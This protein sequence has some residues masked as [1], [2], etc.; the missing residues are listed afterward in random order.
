MNFSSPL[1]SKINVARARRTPDTF[2]PSLPNIM[3]FDGDNTLQ[4]FA[5]Q[6]YFLRSSSPPSVT[7]GT[8]LSKD[9]LSSHR[10]LQAIVLWIFQMDIPNE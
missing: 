10:K 4:C 8:R 9:V 6:F 7:V 1:T 3:P 2:L 5:S